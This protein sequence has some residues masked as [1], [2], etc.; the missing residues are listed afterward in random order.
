MSDNVTLIDL[1]HQFPSL[2]IDLRYASADNLT[3]KPIYRQARCLL[4]PAAVPGLE[5]SINV[6]RLAGFTLQVLDAYR[7]QQAQALLWQACPDTRYVTDTH[8]GS[9]H[10]RGVALDVTLLDHAGLALDMGTA[11][12]EMNPRSHPFYPDLPPQLQRNRLL[13]NAV[14]AAGGFIGIASEWWHFELP[15]AMAFPLLNDRF[16]CYGD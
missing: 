5:R 15:N 13:L 16:A 4:H 3:G 11:F 12:D 9:H 1:A 10:S 8:T 14:M 7:P 2:N 6:A